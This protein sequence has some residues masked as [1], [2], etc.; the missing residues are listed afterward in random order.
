MHGH[1]VC[2]DKLNSGFSLHIFKVISVALLLVVLFF[3]L[4]PMIMYY[5]I[6]V[7]LFYSFCVHIFSSDG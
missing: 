7:I 1:S 2:Q 5:V 3:F 4:W 6:R